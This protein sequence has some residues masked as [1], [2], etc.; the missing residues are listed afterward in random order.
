[1]TTAAAGK[2]LV[3]LAERLTVCCDPGT[4]RAVLDRACGRQLD[5]HAPDGRRAST[6]TVSGI[7]FEAS[8]SGRG[9][10][11]SPTLRYATETATQEMEFGS[12]ITAQIAAIRDLVAWL[13]NGDDNVA[14][15]FQSFVETL[16]PDPAKVPAR[17]GFATWLGL[18]HPAE[19]PHHAARLKL[20]GDPT[21]VPGALHRLRSAWPGFA[22]LAA[23]PDHDTLFKPAIAA[24]EVNAR[25]EVNH[26]IYS[27]A[28]YND[29][30][31]PMKLVRYFGDAAWELLSEFV[32][33][34]VDAATLYQHDVMICCAR[35]AG[36]TEFS[37]S[38]VATPNNDLT[39]V[40][41]ELATR[42]HGTTHAVD[43]LAHAA[44]S[45]GARLTYSAL[46]LGFSPETGIGKLNVYGAPTWD[47]A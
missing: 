16:Y 13:P 42:H 9:G 5:S 39:E 35:G 32:R 11:F 23:V 12:R 30:A 43:A 38:L 33:C 41:R 40:V 2:F 26:K 20:Y 31:L 10:Q 27:R 3:D 1:M 28:R 34:G 6:L 14:D 37:L 18:V 47:A 46:G 22:E 8:V 29:V 24:I 4:I 19:T 25:G 44:Q 15:M 7:P 45:C 36:T 17:H 21:I